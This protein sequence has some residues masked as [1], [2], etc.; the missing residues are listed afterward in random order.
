MKKL[1]LKA[2]S[3]GAREILNREQL[4]A[5]TGGCFTDTDCGSGGSCDTNSNQC[6]GGPSGG[7][8]LPGQSQC[9]ICGCKSAADCA[10]L[11]ASCM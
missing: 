4:K 2:L 5:V 1:R 7:S 8:C 3:L 11:G 6:T 9:G 10:A